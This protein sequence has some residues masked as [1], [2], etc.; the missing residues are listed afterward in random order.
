MGKT[1]HL[2]VGFSRFGEIQ[3]SKGM[4]FHGIGLNAEMLQEFFANEMRWSSIRFPDPEI[5]IGFTE[6][7]G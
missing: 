6:I 5:D 7:N 3:V 4:R 1:T 2:A